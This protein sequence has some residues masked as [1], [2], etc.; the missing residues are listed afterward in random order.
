VTGRD[1]GLL[2]ASIG[3]TQDLSVSA[4]ALQNLGDGTGFVFP[5]VGL[6]LSGATD[7][8]LA[9]QLPYALWGDGGEFRPAADD[10]VVDV[11]PGQ[12]LDLSGL[13]PE[14]TVTLWARVNL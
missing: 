5:T 11:V 9:T 7:L 3:L 12:P 10:L 1:Y 2:T 14:A 8:S 13:V 4:A 6:R